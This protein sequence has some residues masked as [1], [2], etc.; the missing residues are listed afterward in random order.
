[1]PAVK[2]WGI[3][4]ARARDV[5]G[6]DRR[7]RLGLGCCLL[8]LA[9]T[10]GLA[11]EASAT[12]L[13]SKLAAHMTVARSGSAAARLPDGKVLI[14]GGYSGSEYLSSAELFDPATETFEALQAK[15]TAP[16]YAP[17]IV[18]LP[19]GNFLISGG[20][21]VRNAE[22]FDPATDTFEA[23]AAQTVEEREGAVA[24][25]L[26]GGALQNGTVMIA[27]GF[28]GSAVATTEVFYPTTKVFWFI[29]GLRM[30]TPRFAAA[31]AVLPSGNLLIAGGVN[32]QGGGV[33]PQ[34]PR[35][36][37]E[38]SEQKGSFSTLPN[39]M[40]EAREGAAAAAFGNGKVLITGGWDDSD[41]AM[42]TAELFDPAAGTFQKLAAETGNAHALGAAVALGDGDVLVAGGNGGE[43]PLD[44]A[45]LASSSATLTPSFVWSG[46][47]PSTFAWSSTA[48]W[49]GGTAPSAGDSVGTLSFPQLGSSECQAGS[50]VDAC[51]LSFNDLPGLQAE[52]VQLDNGDD[53]LLGG[54]A[55]KLGSGGLTA[56]P[57]SGSVGPS[58]DV[59]ETPLALTAPQEWHLTGR[60]SLANEAGLLL[61]GNVTGPGH[62]LD[63]QMSEESVLY[64]A[65]D[66]IETGPLTLSGANPA[67]AGVFNGVVAL[68]GASLNA[69]SGQPV[70]LS[71]VFAAGSGAVGA[72]E[73]TGAELDVGNPQGKLNAS[74]AAFDSSSRV[75]FAIAG[76]GVTPG[77][78]NS[79]L[80]AQGP[81][82]LGG[83]H[84]EIVVRPPKRG[85]PCP[86]LTRGATYTFVSSKGPLTGAFSNAPA[87][88]PELPVRFAEA[89]PKESRNIHIDYHESG[90]NQT[91]TG[92]VEQDAITREEEAAAEHRTEEEER[93]ARHKQEE[94]AA[95]RRHQEAATRQHQEEES[96]RRARE[97]AVATITPA[98]GPPGPAQGVASFT[99]PPGA[100]S[101]VPDLHLLATNLW[102]DRSGEVRVKL[103]CPAGET[104]CE[105]TLTLKS[106]GATASRARAAALAASTLGAAAFNV[107]G[108]TSATVVL[109]LSARARGLIRAK[110]LL[111]A[112]LSIVAHDL[113]GTTHSASVFVTIHRSR[114]KH[115]GH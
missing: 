42:R 13:F 5:K 98:P 62:A 96:A 17:V 39:E 68:L 23:L 84:L 83:A 105:G 50:E 78:A 11:T 102:A 71:H 115:T 73:S 4:M 113:A 92:T 64:F 54:E 30:A 86:E 21:S 88:G 95:T 2:H 77:T 108:G 90:G 63:A 29:P 94:E 103:A 48:N 87:S 65:E 12:T 47:S 16:R 8:A 33:P 61:A 110:G 91:V 3:E 81:V 75:E 45:E 106:A 93:A 34:W 69:S 10:L 35:S 25:E 49:R 27:G 60:D 107:A 26:P 7:A 51:Y 114:A 31:S 109:H 46:A 20:S 55:L 70:K 104:R 40:V 100:T 37:E 79:Q 41:R 66:D 22:V 112:R 28:S 85:A 59:I 19:D 111:R 67:Q 14:V 99:S 57:A 9:S 36:A 76:A 74:S 6:R 97:Q 52:G 18:P 56:A 53:Y 80:A 82:N 101:T 38:F 44:T 43:G 24:V 32:S 58:G 72:L 1:M 15:M 89:C